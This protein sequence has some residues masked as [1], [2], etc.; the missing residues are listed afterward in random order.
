[1]LPGRAERERE[2]ERESE[3]ARARVYEIGS[4]SLPLRSATATSTSTR[5]AL[6]FAALS[7]R[8]SSCTSRTS[9]LKLAIASMAPASPMSLRF[10]FASLLGDAANSPAYAREAPRAIATAPRER[11]GERRGRVGVEVEVEG[12]LGS[13]L[14]LGL[15]LWVGEG[16]GGG[17][18]MVGPD[19]PGREARVWVRRTAAAEVRGRGFGTCHG[20]AFPSASVSRLGAATNASSSRTSAPPIACSDSHTH[21]HRGGCFAFMVSDSQDCGRAGMS[22]R[23]R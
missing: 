21:W 8:R 6:S 12:K 7:S 2:T 13:W 11:R 22:A 17:G 10:R 16:D 4:T 14:D 9:S 5:S 3:R 19:R 23:D 15:G 20:S 1:M 18:R